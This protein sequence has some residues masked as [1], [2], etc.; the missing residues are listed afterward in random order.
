MKNVATN[1]MESLSKLGRTLPTS[2]MPVM[3][4]N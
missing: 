4:S 3:V 1:A 2:S